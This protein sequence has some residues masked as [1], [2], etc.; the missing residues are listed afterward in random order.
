MRDV[1]IA[2]CL[3][4]L[5]VVRVLGSENVRVEAGQSRE[6]GIGVR[7]S[8]GECV[9]SQQVQAISETTLYCGLES[10]ISGLTEILQTAIRRDAAVLRDG[11]Q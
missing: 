7:E 6:R 8:L 3:L 2:D 11:P 10:L 9:R 1:L 4:T 5:Q